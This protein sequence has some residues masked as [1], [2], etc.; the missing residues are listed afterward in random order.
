MAVIYANVSSS[1]SPQT[2]ISF[3]AVNVIDASDL[4]SITYSPTNGSIVPI[5]RPIEVT[6]V[7]EDKFGNSASCRFW[8]IGKGVTI[9]HIYSYL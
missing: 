4:Q 1:T 6:V 3:P 8:Y 7:A 9:N 2:R 5:D